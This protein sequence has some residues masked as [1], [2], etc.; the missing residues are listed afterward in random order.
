MKQKVVYQSGVYVNKCSK[1]VRRKVG[2]KEKKNPLQTKIQ[3][4]IISKVNET[5]GEE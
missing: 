3:L 4:K 2:R 5:Q 1:Y